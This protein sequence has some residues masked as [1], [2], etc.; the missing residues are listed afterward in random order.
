MLKGPRAPAVKPGRDTQERAAPLSPVVG[1]SDF[2]RLRHLTILLVAVSAPLAMLLHDSDI[3]MNVPC[4]FRD[5]QT[6]TL[7]LRRLSVSPLIM[8]IMILR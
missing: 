8:M 6:I 7:V 4:T 1:Q 2:A 3:P 5:K